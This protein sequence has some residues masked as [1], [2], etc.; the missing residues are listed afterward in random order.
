MSCDVDAAV[1]GADAMM[2]LRIQRERMAGGFLPTT[3]EFHI[4]F[5]LTEE[6]V[7]RAR[8]T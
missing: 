7:K 6:R 3:R 5:G 4:R 8:R 2:M 1:E